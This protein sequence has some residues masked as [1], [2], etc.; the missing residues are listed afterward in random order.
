MQVRGNNANGAALI[1]APC[2]GKKGQPDNQ[3]FHFVQLEGANGRFIQ[4]TTADFNFDV[5]GASTDAGTT[6]IL[7]T[8]YSELL[9]QQWNLDSSH[10]TF[11]RWVPFHTVWHSN[12]MCLG[13]K[14]QSLTEGVELTIQVCLDNTSQII[15]PDVWPF[16]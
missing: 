11:G 8:T 5:S 10:Y 6:T 14:D 15:V 13:T 9:H 3:V 2:T 7:W 1:L 4:T 12:P 16:H